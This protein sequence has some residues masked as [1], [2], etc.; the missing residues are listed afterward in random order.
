MTI[1]L[2]GLL[3]FLGS[4]ALFALVV[5]WL[6]ARH[7]RDP[8]HALAG[9]P[10]DAIALATPGGFSLAGLVQAVSG[11]PF[12]ELSDQ[13]NALA[14]WQRGVYGVGIFVAACVVVFGGLLA[15]ALYG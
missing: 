4:G 2:R 10:F 3:Q 5:W 15:F 1:R 11:V 8:S 6:A 13:W 12:A 7:A 14:G 9:N